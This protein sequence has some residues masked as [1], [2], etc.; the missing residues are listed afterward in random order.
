MHETLRH[1]R[2]A[3]AARARE[4][5]CMRRAGFQLADEAMVDLAMAV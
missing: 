4:E 2:L 1:Q 5:I 3:Y